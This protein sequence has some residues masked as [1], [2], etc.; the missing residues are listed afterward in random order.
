MTVIKSSVKKKNFN[1]ENEFIFYKEN[2]D[3]KIKLCLITHLKKVSINEK[4]LYFD[5]YNQKK[6][7]IK[8]YSFLNNRKIVIMDIDCPSIDEIEQYI[9]KQKPKYIFISYY[10]L[11]SNKENLLIMGEKLGYILN[12]IEEYS[13]KYGV[14]FIVAINKEN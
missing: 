9:I 1:D 7:L 8:K 10:K 11:V 14:K 12:K 5:F 13:M 6:D 3:E 4:I 2:D